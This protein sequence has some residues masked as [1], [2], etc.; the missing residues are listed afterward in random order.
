[1]L[2]VRNL[3]LFPEDGS[4]EVFDS[5]VNLLAALASAVIVGFVA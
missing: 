4:N 2:R 3:L 1:M 5:R